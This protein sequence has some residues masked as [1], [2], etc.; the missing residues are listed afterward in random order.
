MGEVQLTLFDLF[1]GG[2]GL[3]SLQALGSALWR[4]YKSRTP[5]AQRA[6]SLGEAHKIV[7]T[8]GIAN[9]QLRLDNERLRLWMKEQREEF[10][11]ERAEDKAEYE[12]DL[13]RL[14]EQL[15]EARKQVEDLEARLDAILVENLR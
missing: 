12:A 15:T 2:G 7:V 8:A 4:H 13:R 9:D 3:V 1:I 5:A 6:V 11:K 10:E 14:R